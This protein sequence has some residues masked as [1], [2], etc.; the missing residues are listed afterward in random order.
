METSILGVLMERLGQG[1]SAERDS[2]VPTASK[3]NR[4]NPAPLPTDYKDRWENWPGG[5]YG[6]IDAE[7]GRGF[8]LGYPKGSF[9]TFVRGR[10]EGLG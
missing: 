5:D 4:E 9:S 3:R 1:P 7:T 10:G 8:V 6:E 2:P